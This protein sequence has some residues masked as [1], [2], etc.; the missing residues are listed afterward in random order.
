MKYLLFIFFCFSVT[1]G[2]SQADTSFHLL[3]VIKGDILDFTVDNLNNTYIINS[4][5]QLKKINADGYIQ[6]P[7]DIHTFKE[8][9]AQKIQA[10]AM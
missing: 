5:H 9:I 2:F 8:T 7:F 10:D 1:S 4:K 3:R 6:K